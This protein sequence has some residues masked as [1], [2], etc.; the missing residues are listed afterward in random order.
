VRSGKTIAEKLVRLAGSQSAAARALGC[1]QPTVWAWLHGG[2][3]SGGWRKLAVQIIGEDR[4]RGGPAKRR[5]EPR[6]VVLRTK[7]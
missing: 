6:R 7:D 5:K 3:M 2:G 4:E 1:T